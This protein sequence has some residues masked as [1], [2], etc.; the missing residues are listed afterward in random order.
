MPNRD[1]SRPTL[2]LLGWSVPVTLTTTLTAVVLGA[3]VATACVVVVSGGGTEN[4]V[5]PMP[6]DKL[7]APGPGPAF[8]SAIPLP[9]DAL[10]AKRH[11][12]NAAPPDAVL[13]S[14]SVTYSWL[15]SHPPGNDGDEAGNDGRDGNI[16]TAATVKDAAV[17]DLNEDMNGQ[18]LTCGTTCTSEP[19][20][21]ERQVIDHVGPSLTVWSTAARA[22][23]EAEEVKAWLDMQNDPTYVPYSAFRWDVS[24]WDDVTVTG[25]TAAAVFEGKGNYLIN[26][27][28]QPDE[29]L[30]Q[31]Q[32]KLVLEQGS[33]RL[34]DEEVLYP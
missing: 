29:T 14:A 19:P 2:R 11:L 32:L 12:Q 22:T 34:S 30:Q 16:N 25:T 18:A 33:W 27:S 3:G 24:K 20:L 4:N 15:P 8:N 26:G 10:A 5:A 23:K 13:P 7:T 17:A 1:P 9:A 21:S 31:V 6:P 28:W